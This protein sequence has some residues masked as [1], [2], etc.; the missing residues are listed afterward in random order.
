MNVKRPTRRGFTLVELLV[1]IGIISVLVGLLL[2]ALSQARAVANRTKC[3]ANLNQLGVAM[4]TYANENR[5]LLIPLGPLEDGIQDAADPSCPW[6]SGKVGQDISVSGVKSYAYQTLGTEVYPWVRWPAAIFGRPYSTAPNPIPVG[7]PIPE[8]P[9]D[10]MGIYSAAWT[11][12]IL[13]CPSDPQPGASH[14]Y[15]FNQHMVADQQQVLTYT[16][17]APAGQSDTQVVVLGEKRTGVDDYYMEAG[18]FPIN[19]TAVTTIKVEL[20]RHGAKLGSNYLYKGMH[21]VAQPPSALTKP[22][23]PWDIVPT[24]IT[25]TGS[26]S[27]PGT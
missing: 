20:Y 2:P 3:L 27:N 17:R 5:G 10:P 14:S 12:P 13:A 1:V 9:G 25:T 22:V 26:S 15:M 23:D 8:G 6:Q 18:D 19:G 11:P 4:L 21:A 24:P 16:R 7:Q